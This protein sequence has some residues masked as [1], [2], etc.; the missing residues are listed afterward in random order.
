MST[1]MVFY[2]PG[3]RWVID[4]VAPDGLG[5]YGRRSLEEVQAEHPMA[6]VI[7]TEDAR[8]QIEALTITKPAR[9]DAERF[10][11]M[12]EVLPPLQWQRGE[13]FESFRMS[14]FENGRCT[15]VVVRRGTGDCA[16]YWS[17][18]DVYPLTQ[19]EMVR[20]IGEAVMAE[21]TGAAS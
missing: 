5:R 7:S 12:L 18:T 6:V 13:Y 10:Q 19:T 4:A 9:I 3:M 15:A 21:T 1:E 20:K 14:E 16:E 2:A 8:A 17:W 11:Y